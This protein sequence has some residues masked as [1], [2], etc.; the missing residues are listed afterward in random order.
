MA[1]EQQQQQPTQQDDL[2]AADG[3]KVIS[4]NVGGESYNLETT[5][6]AARGVKEAIEAEIEAVKL[7]ALKRG[8]K[9]VKI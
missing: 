4:F 8:V 3:R 5:E 2:T 6:Q 7:G 9:R 1:N